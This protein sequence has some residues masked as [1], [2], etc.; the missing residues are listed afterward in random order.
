MLFG[1]VSLVPASIN[2]SPLQVSEPGA[3]QTESTVEVNGAVN[4]HFVSSEEI[5]F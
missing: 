5:I 4:V 2:E 1:M 3:N